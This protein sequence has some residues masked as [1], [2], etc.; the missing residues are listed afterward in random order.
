MISTAE[1]LSLSRRAHRAIPAGCHTYSKGDDQF[2]CNAP[3]FIVSGKGAHVRDTAGNEFL[4][5]GMGLRSV[6]LGHAHPGVVDAVVAELRRGSNFTRPSPLETLLAEDLIE[7]IPCAE[8]VKFAKNGSD[9]TTAS[10]RLARAATGRDLVAF[11]REHPFHSADDWFIGTTPVDAGVPDATKRLSLTFPYGDLRAL[12]ELFVAHPGQIAAVIMEP[13]TDAPPPTGYLE[14]V[15]ELTRREGAVLIF[16]EII[17]GFR[18]HEGGAQT[19]YG[20]T[21]D[22]ATFGKA[23]A[24]GFSVTALVGRREIMELGG[25]EHDRP[26]VFLLSSTHGGET[27][28]LAAARATIAEIREVEAVGHIWRIGAELQKGL[29]AAARA[30]GVAAVVS[31]RGYP[32][33]PVLT[34]DAGEP[35][36]SAALR[37]LFLQ[38]TVADG[39]LMPYI[40]PSASHCTDDVDR[41]SE[42][43]ARA[44]ARVREALDGAP[45]SGL[46][47]GPSVKPVFRRFNA[48]GVTT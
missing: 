39:I 38:E 7:L 16:D 28:S 17:T 12:R 37:T 32:C 2:P 36:Y 29:E 3:G 1:T 18:W 9:V 42:A 15:R 47:R 33:S 5:W 31:F 26:R 34:F 24:N 43:A 11:P 22:M 6:I 45:L 19:L 4:D 46:L 21:P 14:G 30:A 48:K 13:A 40:A 27:H 8:M 23:I 25:L 41:T 10:L 35:E 20:V 44:F